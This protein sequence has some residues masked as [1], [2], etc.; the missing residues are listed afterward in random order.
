MYGIVLLKINRYLD[1]TVGQIAITRLQL[2]CWTT[3]TKIRCNFRNIARTKKFVNEN[4]DE[5]D[6]EF[7]AESISA[8]L[9]LIE[10]TLNPEKCKVL[11]NG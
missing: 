3:G 2:K 8:I 1:N 6:S 11:I 10:I 5:T 7:G 4:F 9:K